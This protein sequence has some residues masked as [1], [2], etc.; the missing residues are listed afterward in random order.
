[1]K[2][3]AILCVLFGHQPEH[4]EVEKT[5][6]TVRFTECARCHARKDLNSNEWIHP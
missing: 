5:M 3:R 2:L 6:T 4:Y 1:M